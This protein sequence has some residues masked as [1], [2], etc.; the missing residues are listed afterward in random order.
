MVT[1]VAVVTVPAVTGNVAEVEPCGTVTLAGTLATNG[2]ALRPIVAP[3][4]GAADVRATVHVEPADGERL[5]GVQERLLNSAVCSNVTVPPLTVVAIAPPAKSADTP[6]V[7]WTVEEESVIEGA[8]ASVTD[9]STLFG[10]LV[11]FKPQT[12]QVAVPVPFTQ[13]SVLFAAPVPAATV[14]DVKSVVE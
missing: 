13:E 3:P 11:E 5:V 1:D 14:A 8:T 6:F 7:N 10:M 4:L 12:R 9:A 2:D